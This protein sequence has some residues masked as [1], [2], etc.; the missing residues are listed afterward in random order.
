MNRIDV[1]SA[2][3]V[4]TDTTNH[5]N[6]HQQTA[7]QFLHRDFVGRSAWLCAVLAWIVVTAYIT[8]PARAQSSQPAVPGGGKLTGDM[9]IATDYS[10]C[11]WQILPDGE[12]VVF[13]AGKKPSVIVHTVPIAASEPPRVLSSPLATRYTVEPYSI[14]LNREWIL[15]ETETDAPTRTELYAAPF[16]GGE[17]TLLL[18]EE[19]TATTS[20]VYIPPGDSI[21]L[22]EYYTPTAQSRNFYVQQLPSGERRLITSFQSGSIDR[23]LTSVSPDGQ[24]LL[25]S[26][27]SNDDN[28]YELSVVSTSNGALQQLTTSSKRGYWG[29]Y[30]LYAFWTADSKYVVFQTHDGNPCRVCAA[31]IT[32]NAFVEL[33][34]TG[35]GTLYD[36]KAKDV[37]S[38]DGQYVLVE[39]KVTTQDPETDNVVEKIEMYKV[40]IVDGAA[41]S[42]T[43]ALSGDTELVWMQFAPT[44]NALFLLFGGCSETG[45]GEDC[46]VSFVHS[47]ADGA[48][49]Q[50]VPLP[51]PD[52]RYPGFHPA[53]A[54]P[55]IVLQAIF[56]VRNRDE[57][58]SYLYATYV[59]P[60]DS[61]QPILAVRFDYDANVQALL[62]PGGGWL[63]YSQRDPTTGATT[64]YATRPGSGISS[65]IAV[66]IAGFDMTDH[67]VVY[68]GAKNADGMYD[69]FSSRLLDSVFLPLIEAP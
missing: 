13:A 43:P 3:Y 60:F 36:S 38:A 41:F 26:N 55:G 12:H 10:C 9:Q 25:V 24:W 47:G 29:T 30:S 33:D 2:P 15:Y 68:G 52:D 37:I 19:E 28:R 64:L 20:F 49:L 53:N 14:S 56:E 7:P 57:P 34:P 21:L 6:Q 40:R 35:K 32:T 69:L 22:Q 44:G 59:V 31:E 5:E 65:R 48:P 63:V 18:N 11:K 62:S 42:V 54:G 58:A 23:L 61:P 51:S 45:E 17:S 8:Q 67:Y 27:D 4:V 16:D 66:D 39:S 50:P 1:T 46:A